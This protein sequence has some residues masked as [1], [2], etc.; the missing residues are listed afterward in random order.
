MKFL[1]QSIFYKDL[2]RYS[3]SQS[4]HVINKNKQLY[5]DNL[6]PTIPKTIHHVWFGH[7]K[8]PDIVEYCLKSCE[9][10]KEFGYQFKLWDE[11]NFPLEKYPFAEQAYKHK[12]WAFVSDVARLHAT[13]YD[14]GIYLDT[15]MEVLKPFDDLL[16]QDAFCCQESPTLISVGTLGAKKYNPVIKSF[17]DFYETTNYS[18][19][20]YY[21]TANT[22]IL[23]KIYHKLIIKHNLEQYI[24]IYPKDYFLGE[25]NN[26]DSY[27]V[28]H[29]TGLW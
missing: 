25:K 11:S 21:R 17:L 29:G 26:S 27:T 20:G 8:K 23:Y 4:S 2:F 16:S 28:H 24:K 5:L 14:G 3:L 6:S 9:F 18:N 1:E 7:N 13:Y 22:R 12:K 19:L 15:D 10:L